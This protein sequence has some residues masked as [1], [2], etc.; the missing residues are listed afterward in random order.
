MGSQHVII[1]SFAGGEISPRLFG[2]ADQGIWD[3]AVAKMVNFAPTVEGP[4]IK[5]SGAQ[6]AGLAP[7]GATAILPFEYNTTQSYALVFSNNL[8]TVFYDGAILTSGGSPVTIATPY[9]AADCPAIMWQQDGDVLYLCHP[10][11]PP[12]SINRTGAAT[13]T[14]TPLALTSGPYQQSNKTRNKTITPSGVTAGAS[15]NL[16]A[17]GAVFVAGHVGAS[18][19]LQVADFSAYP[20]WQPG[21][22]ISVGTA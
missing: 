18:I 1:D 21:I 3:I 12:A 20:Q 11:Y 22:Q 8:V 16:T 5:R 9:A 10:G 14:Y 7:T 19:Q 15:V 4:A 2:R 17:S 6:L 13:F